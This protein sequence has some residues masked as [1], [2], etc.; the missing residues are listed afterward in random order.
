MYILLMNN[1]T[2]HTYCTYHP[3]YLLCKVLVFNCL[4]HFF[5]AVK[6]T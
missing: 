4:A 1:D 6:Y 3:V 5:I 2:E